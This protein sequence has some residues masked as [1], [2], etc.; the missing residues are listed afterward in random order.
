MGLHIVNVHWNHSN[1]IMKNSTHPFTWLTLGVFLMITFSIL[2]LKY[3]VINYSW[4]ELYKAFM[5]PDSTSVVFI[6]LFEVRLPIVLMSIL[7]GAALAISG[8]LLQRVTQNPLACPSLSGVEYGTACCVILSYMFIPQV[9]KLFIMLISLTGGLLTY[10]LTQSI[11]SKTG[12][13]TIGITLIGVAFDALYFSAIQA[14]LL[15]FPY[16]A[17]AILYDMNGSM[18]GLTMQDVK[19]IAIP[20]IFLFVMAF[21]FANRLNLLDLDEFQASSLGVAIK[22]YRL[23]MLALSIAFATL[24]TSMM[25][26]L[27][28]FSLIVPHIVKSFARGTYTVLFCTIFGATFLLIAEFVTQIITPQTPPPVGLI[29]LLIAAPMLII[30]VRGYSTYAES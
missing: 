12:V 8:L 20:L 14:I 18:Q 13:T 15:A 24:I 28:F 30:L 5:H 21:I 1:F 6:T 9:S 10:L 26:P 17:Q 3:G 19:L 2:N 27:L 22:K 29:I 16:Q 11:I 4:M 23:F 7:A 25:G